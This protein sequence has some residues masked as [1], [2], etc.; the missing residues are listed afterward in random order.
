MSRCG[1]APAVFAVLALGVSP[2]AASSDLTRVH[3][4]AG[5]EHYEWKEFF[6]DGATAVKETGPF[7]TV[8]GGWD[9][10]RRDSEGSLY[11]VDGYAYLGRVDYSGFS[12]D[13]NTG[14]LTPLQSHTDYNGVHAT[15]FG[16]YRFMRGRY[17][18]DLIGGGGLDSWRRSLGTALDA[19]GNVSSGYVENYAIVNARLAAALFR[20]LGS[21]SYRVQAGAKYPVY[22]YEHVSFLDGMDLSPGKRTSFFGEVSFEFGPPDRSHYGLS[23]GFDSY[24]FSPSDPKLLTYNGLP[25]TDQYG[26]PLYSY[27]PKSEQ[28]IYTLNLSYYFR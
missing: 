22:T 6:S 26:R 20:D 7:P 24:R 8:G 17:G 9:D 4:Q 2:M 3:L 25:V 13:L 14:T 19:A 10:L 1:L 15:G 12:Q 5:I 27:Q 28:T 11:G 23:L 21:W 16:G 18:L